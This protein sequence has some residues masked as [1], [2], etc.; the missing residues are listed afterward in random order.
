MPPQLD[1]GLHGVFHGLS[2]CEQFCGRPA[3]SLLG[4][5]GD[6]FLKLRGLKS[7]VVHLGAVGLEGNQGLAGFIPRLAWHAFTQIAKSAIRGI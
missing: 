6:R 1:R 2:R 3:K 4:Q 7:Q 5:F